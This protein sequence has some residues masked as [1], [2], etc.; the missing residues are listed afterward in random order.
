[1]ARTLQVPAGCL[2]T[3]A[4]HDHPVEVWGLRAL[5][6][7][8]CDVL[9]VRDV[10]AGSVGGGRGAIHLHDGLRDGSSREGAKRSGTLSRRRSRRRM[11][12][13][14]SRIPATSTSMASIRP[15]VSKP[16]TRRSGLVSEMSR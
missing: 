5:R 6:V 1:M 11:R 2:Q 15:V 13:R 14:Q 9:G 3:A 16:L 7:R 8:V 10:P 4:R 12:C